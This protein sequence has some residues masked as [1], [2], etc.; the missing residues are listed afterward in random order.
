MLKQLHPAIAL[1]LIG[2]VTGI[3]NHFIFLSNIHFSIYLLGSVI[4]LAVAAYL[5][6]VWSRPL[7]AGFIIFAGCT[8]SWNAA[9]HS[10]VWIVVEFEIPDPQFWWV[11]G[12]TGSLGAV[13]FF[14]GFILAMSKP[15]VPVDLLRTVIVGMC[16]GT[17]TGLDMETGLVLFT[18]WQGA[19]AAS[20]GRNRG[21]F[22]VG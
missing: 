18:I 8:L 13:I 3:I 12:L 9:V 21:V 7:W 6:I 15:L 20:L 16:A 17:L 14:A 1:G 11:G 10:A 19:V 2:L 4:G 22:D 5:V